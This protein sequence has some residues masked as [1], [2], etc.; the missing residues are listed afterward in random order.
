M[1]KE[2]KE[3]KKRPLWKKIVKGVFGL[4]GAVL[5]LAIVLVVVLTVTEY[6][7]DEEEA[8]EVQGSGSETMQV[9]DDL[10]VLTWNI[11]YGC[12]GET[13]DFLV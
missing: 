10:T 6:K 8:L 2:R 5:A 9:G 13:A 3:S 7:P 11:G 12:L 1:E 4:I